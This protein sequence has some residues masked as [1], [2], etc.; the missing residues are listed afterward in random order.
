MA[1][2]GNGELERGSVARHKA[3]QVPV[4]SAR[5]LRAESEVCGVRKVVRVDG[6][7]QPPE[8]LADAVRCFDIPSESCFCVCWFAPIVH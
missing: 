6:Q 7:G 4:A 3:G 8:R 1:G 2:R 5:E